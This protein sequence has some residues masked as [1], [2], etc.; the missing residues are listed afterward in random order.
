MQGLFPLASSLRRLFSDSHV[1]FA[2]KV[3]IAMLGALI[4]ALSTGTADETVLMS[5]GI[6]A[7]AIGE[8]DDSVPG[9]VK[10]LAVTMICFV[11]ATLSVQGLYPF[12]WLFAVGLFISTFGFIML[13][14]LGPRYATISFGSLLVA[15]YSMLG[16]AH[17]T[18][19]WHQPLWLCLGA[20]WYGLISL[21]WLKLLPHKAVHEQ[22]AQ[23]FF[24]LGDYCAEKSRLF[25]VSPGQVATIRHQLA[26]LNVR[27]VRSMQVSREMLSGRLTAGWDPHL[28]RLLQ[29]YL[30][31]QEIHE[32]MVASHWLYDRLHE[33]LQ[34]HAIL[35]GFRTT[36]AQLSLS[37][38]QLGNAVLWHR[39]YQPADGLVWI[40]RALADQQTL[41]RQQQNLPAELASGLAFL[42][43]NLQAMLD[44]LQASVALTSH[45]TAPVEEV[46]NRQLVQNPPASLRHVRHHWQQRTPLLRHGLR[47]ATALTLSYG[48]L[49]LFDIRQGFWVLLTCL[50]V[51]QASY[52]A[53]RRRVW[54]RIG[55]TLLGLV[56]ATP[57]ALFHLPIPVLLAGM[58]V[59]AVLFFSQLRNNYSAAVTFI[60][61]YALTAFTLLGADSELLLMPR[62]FDT[63]LGSAIA[64]FAVMV[65]WP[66]WQYR[67]LP[68]LITQ[69]LEACRTYLQQAL[70]QE[71]GPDQDLHYRIARRQAHVS[72]SALAEAWQ[73]MLAEPKHKQRFLNL[74]VALTQ[75]SH[76][77]LS[78][79]STLGAH[80]DR[81][82]PQLT[83]EQR[84]LADEI[85]RV[86]H[87]AAQIMAGQ[88]SVDDT[89]MS[90]PEACVEIEASAEQWLIQQELVFIASQANELLRLSW[91][92]QPLQLATR[93]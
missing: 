46:S 25:P 20:L 22:L 11:I 27:S 91:L 12:P 92:L 28:E 45:Y 14:A 40:L 8:P 33:D 80:R 50:F 21:I 44:S 63:I 31:G 68:G 13:G 67:R 81:L 69:T 90:L 17:A 52:S 7:G 79:I 70:Q 26:Q 75:R 47:M 89:P 87:S 18:N 85:G 19:L 37:I 78:F 2:L 15:I 66:E 49:E 4:P 73:N 35:D 34:Q 88:G 55:G 42:Q 36:L 30:L 59:A 60:T 38:R 53:T 39:P 71:S 3:F 83:A 1:F 74:C 10:N 65:L 9:R 76:T 23:M 6:V 72:D 51:C 48:L 41:I 16:V 32:K 57:I 43:Q 61:L 82:R 29:I 58:V 5:L 93:Q 62:L 84:Q 24:A 77:L 56:L 86:L 54:E 64:F